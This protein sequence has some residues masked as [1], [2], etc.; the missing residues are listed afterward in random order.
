MPTF[1]YQGSGANK[2]AKCPPGEY[3]AT[4]ERVEDRTGGVFDVFFTVIVDAGEVSE[5]R[6]RQW[7]NKPNMAWKVGR[8]LKCLGYWKSEPELG[9]EQTFELEQLVG[10]RG[11]IKVTHKKQVR[12]DGS[13][14][15]FVN[16]EY[17]LGAP[18]V[19]RPAPAAVEDEDN[20]NF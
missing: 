17:L 18:A 10:L 13:E 6:D 9:S 3:M 11:R 1:M 5:V 4:V 7:L 2:P 19:S 8:M 20:F 14:A 16:V 15:T 12:D